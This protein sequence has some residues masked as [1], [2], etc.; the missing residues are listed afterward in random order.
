MTM[1]KVYICEMDFHGK[2]PTEEDYIYA[3]VKNDAI[4]Y[5]RKQCTSS[6]EEINGMSGDG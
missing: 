4:D 3:L 2:F 5:Q 6:E 1:R